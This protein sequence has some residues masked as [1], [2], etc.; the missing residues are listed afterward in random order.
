MG[1][2]TNET[3]S[4]PI[5]ISDA[6]RGVKMERDNAELREQLRICDEQR[7]FYRE[8]VNVAELACEANIKTIARLTEALKCLA[9]SHT[10]EWWLSGAPE[11]IAENALAQKPNNTTPCETKPT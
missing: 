5:Q 10:P 6:E 9:L 2:Q 8:G 1:L 7:E 3:V 4:D 11:Q